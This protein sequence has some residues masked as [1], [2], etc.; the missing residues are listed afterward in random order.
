M[1][2]EVF[3][4]NIKMAFGSI[5]TQLLRTVLTMLIIAFGIT[6]L[7]GILTSTTALEKTISGQFSELGATTFTVQNRGVNVQI[8]RRRGAPKPKPKITL[9]Q[10]RKLTDELEQRGV[11]RSISFIATG[12]AEIKAGSK[13]TNPNINI[14]GAEGDYLQTSGYS[15][16]EGRYF[17]P[18]EQQYGSPVVVLGSD[19]AALLFGNSSALDNS[20]QV[21]GKR[22][23]VIGVLQP[24]GN[25]SSFGGDKVVI[26][27]LKNAEILYPNSNRSF[28]INAMAA[29]A[30]NLEALIT[31][32]TGLMRGIKKLK[33]GEENNFE[34]TK[35]DNLSQLLISNL[36]YVSYAATG[37]GL[38]TLL[39]AA[40][41]LMNIMLVSVTERTKEIGI[42]KALGASALSIRQQFL[43]EAVVLSILG[44]LLGIVMGIGMGNLT[45]FFI[46]SGFVIP[47]NWILLALTLCFFTGVIAGYYPASKASKL[48]PVEALR[49]E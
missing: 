24:K 10:A 6:A 30:V 45:A 31:E 44:G 4:E 3:R 8:G 17:T 25:S 9:L 22:Y 26:M 21:K 36:S 47:W 19:L 40:V 41:A 15:L 38:I 13:K 11:L 42:R 49:Y 20:I 37:I 39:G 16:Q 14:W 48:D 43:V 32:T 2:K 33:P 29:D 18:Q 34:I 5:R 12:Q 28:A 23:K 1:K 35:S 7:V 27:P 46:G